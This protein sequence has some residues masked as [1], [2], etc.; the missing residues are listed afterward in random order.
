M[1]RWVRT[2]ISIVHPPVSV[3][4]QH[5]TQSPAA[6]FGQDEE[7]EQRLEAHAHGS[8]SKAGVKPRSEQR[9]GRRRRN[10]PAHAACGGF[11]LFGRVSLHPTFC[12]NELKPLGARAL[13]H[14]ERRHTHSSLLKCR[15]KLSLGDYTPVIKAHL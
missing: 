10:P 11:F 13:A 14:F 3:E 5:E 15:R 9:A 6:P 12:G 4:G 7:G 8:G 2:F 1:L